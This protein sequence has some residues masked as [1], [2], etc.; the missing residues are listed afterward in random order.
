M[1]LQPSQPTAASIL[2]AAQHEGAWS[3]PVELVLACTGS[4]L[5]DLVLKRFAR[6]DYPKP[7]ARVIQRG[8]QFFAQV[9]FQA[10][11]FTAVFLPLDVWTL[12]SPIGGEGR[13]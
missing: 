5:K 12:E 10:E 3:V 8:Q 13:S 7:S 4:V 2:A 11:R 9:E 6:G 1:S